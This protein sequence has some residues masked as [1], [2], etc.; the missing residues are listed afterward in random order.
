MITPSFKVTCRLIFRRTTTCISAVSDGLCSSKDDEIEAIHLF[1]KFADQRV[2][3]TD[4]ISFVLMKRFR[5][6]TAFTFDQ[7][8]ARAGF[9]VIPL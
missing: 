4:C 2:S 1:R 3:F 5:I 8:F 6:R 7:H 9:E